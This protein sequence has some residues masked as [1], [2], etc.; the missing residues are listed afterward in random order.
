M[1]EPKAGMFPRTRNLPHPSLPSHRKGHRAH[2]GSPFGL[3]VFFW[4]PGGPRFPHLF[5][6][7]KA[8]AFDAFSTLPEQI[9]QIQPHPAPA[10]M[11]IGHFSSEVPH[12]FPPSFPPK[13]S[14]IFGS[15]GSEGFQGLAL[16]KWGNSSW[17]SWTWKGGK[18]YDFPVSR[19]DY[20][21]NT[22]Y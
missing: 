1:R 16:G 14:Q 3:V 4:A 22:I 18:V 19:E 6:G 8:P 12:S 11:E 20:L 10:E 15:E 17:T 9:S 2:L 5:F 7:S 13:T 21:G